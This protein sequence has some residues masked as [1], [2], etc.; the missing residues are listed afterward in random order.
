MPATL[1]TAL[2]ATLLALVT[3]AH[4]QVLTPPDDMNYRTGGVRFSIVEETPG[5]KQVLTANGKRLDITADW[6][7]IRKVARIGGETVLVAE[8]G[9]AG[10]CCPPTVVR[11]VSV[12][13]SGTYVVVPGVIEHVEGVDLAVTQAGDRLRVATTRQAGKRQVP[14]RYEYVSGRM[15][16]L[17]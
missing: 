17:P 4:A 1:A 12:D 13:A 11:L 10:D 2:L 5:G 14:Q 6:L 3:G 15:R 9:K 16:K 8:G 7:S